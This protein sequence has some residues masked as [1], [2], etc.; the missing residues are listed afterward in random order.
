[1]FGSLYGKPDPF[2]LRWLNHPSYDR[3]WQKMVPRGRE[4]AK[5]D[6]PVLTMTGYYAVGEAGAL[7][8]FNEQRRYDKHANHTLLI[9]PYD[10]AATQ[11]GAQPVLRGYQVDPAALV[12]LRELRY[13]W[14]DH[15]LKGAAAPGLL[16]ERVNYE[17]MGANEWRHAPSL[18]AMA[19]GSLRLY[20]DPTAV[21]ASHRLAQHKVQGKTSNTKGKPSDS[22]GKSSAAKNK[23]SDPGF[24]A[25]VV[26][27]AD[28]SDANSN[29]MPTD[30]T[31]K[32]VEIRNATTFVSAPLPRALELQGAWSGRFD[33]TVNTMDVDLRVAA[34]ELLPGG[35]Y[36]Q[37]FEPYAFRASYAR[38]RVHRHLLKAG[39]RQPLPFKIDRLTSRRLQA[40]SRLVLV[41]AVNKRPDEE[42]NYGTG[43]D[44][45]SESLGDDKVPVKIRWYGDSY[46]EI[47]VRR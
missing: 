45:S 25:Q 26:S 1:D 18:E 29:W 17:V 13:Q 23:P 34:Y 11:R 47:P 42:I 15:V 33:L 35:D 27:L 3:F 36:V 32:S 10:D 41:L 31:G 43:E 4:L 44:V 40:G 22:G 20:L 8:Y 37:L 30:I 9:G 19:N 39:E 21:G 12:D 24:V 46:I 38:D 28:R 14:F 6:I 7:Y 5:V 16:Q 2:F